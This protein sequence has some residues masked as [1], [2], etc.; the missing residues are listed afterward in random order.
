M[1]LHHAADGRVVR[2]RFLLFSLIGER[3]CDTRVERR[4]PR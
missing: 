2:A 4:D 3:A 1:N